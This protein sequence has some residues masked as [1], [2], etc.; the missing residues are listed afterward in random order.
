MRGPFEEPVGA[1]FVRIPGTASAENPRGTMVEVYGKQ[2]DSGG[3]CVSGTHLQLQYLLSY[4]QCLLWLQ[5]HA[6]A[7]GHD[8]FVEL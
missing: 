8:E 7:A 5:L 6:E 1:R 4:N 3:F 2:D